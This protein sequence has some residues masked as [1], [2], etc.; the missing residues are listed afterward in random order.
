MSSKEIIW[1]TGICLYS[2]F[3]LS[4]VI[5][6]NTKCRTLEETT[7]QK[8]CTRE[9]LL[10]PAEHSLQSELLSNISSK[11]ATSC[12]QHDQGLR[13]PLQSG[14]PRGNGDFTVDQTC[15]IQFIFSEVPVTRCALLKLFIQTLLLLIS[16]LHSIKFLYF[17][18]SSE[19]NP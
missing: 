2:C 14:L 4:T 9:S 16:S 18:T 13:S 12:L 17:C 6:G 1:Q 15:L 8:Q 5:E 7:S 10:S 11:R 19:E 3:S